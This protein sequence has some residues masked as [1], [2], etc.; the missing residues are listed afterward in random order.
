M[1]NF[2]TSFALAINQRANDRLSSQ[3]KSPDGEDQFSVEARLAKYFWVC[4]RGLGSGN[5]ASTS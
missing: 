1:I 2:I 3:V 5:L 4:L